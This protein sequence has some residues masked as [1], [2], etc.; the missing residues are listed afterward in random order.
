MEVLQGRSDIG[1]AVEVEGDIGR[2]VVILVH[3]PQLGILQVDDVR[4]TASGVEDVGRA[5]EEL[6]VDLPH[7]LPI[8]VLIRPLHLIQDYPLQLPPALPVQLPPPPLL[9]EIEFMQSCLKSHVQVHPVEVVPVGGIGGGEEVGG[10]VVASP[11][12]HVGI[13]GASQHVEEGVA[14]G[15]LLRPAGRQVLQD[16]RTSAVG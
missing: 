6:L 13:D 4:G 11:G 1:I 5:P 14:D 8:S 2:M 7:Q 16:V 15:V 12:V 10:E 3:L 9:P